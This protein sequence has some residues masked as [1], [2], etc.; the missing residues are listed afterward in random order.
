MLGTQ[1]DLEVVG[2]AVSGS[3][4]VRLAGDLRPDVTLMDLQMPELDGATAISRIRE[5][6]PRARVIVLTTYDTDNDI[7]RAI[8]A[9]AI[10]Y[11]LKDTHREQLFDAIRAAARGRAPCRRRSRPG[12]CRGRAPTR[13]APSAAG[14]SRSWAR[15]PRG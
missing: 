14:R 6:D 1:D 8:D 2:E 15:S 7:F 12:W 10:G 3:D 11:L 13:P 5:H 4:A 9:G